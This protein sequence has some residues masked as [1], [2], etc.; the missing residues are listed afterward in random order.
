LIIEIN[1]TNAQGWL[2]KKAWEWIQKYQIR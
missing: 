1:P 2:P